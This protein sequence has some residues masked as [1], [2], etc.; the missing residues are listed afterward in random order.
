MPRAFLNKCAWT[1]ASAGTGDFILSAALAGF[2]APVDCASPAVVDGALYRYFAVSSDGSEHEEGDGA[3]DVATSTLARTNIRNSSNLGSKVDFA[4]APVIHMG[5]AA[6]EDMPGEELLGFVDLAA[7]GGA[8]VVT[9]DAD[10]GDF[11]SISVIIEDIGM[12]TSVLVTD[13]DYAAARFQ[14]YDASD[15]PLLDGETL[16]LP[17]SAYAYLNSGKIDTDTGKS[18]S[19]FVW[20]EYEAAWVGSSTSQTWEDGVSIGHFTN[21]ANTDSGSFSLVTPPVAPVTLKVEAYFMDALTG[22]YG[23]PPNM[24]SGKIWFYGRRK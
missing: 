6:A 8:S 17:A 19:Q 22:D 18:I 3:W 21:A 16:A 1:P 7:E 20:N 24:T 9:L 11:L 4:A 15:N 2:Y 5:G 23:T 13:G 14:F 12:D 10:L